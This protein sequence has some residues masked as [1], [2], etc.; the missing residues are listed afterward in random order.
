MIIRNT[1]I[2]QPRAAREVECQGWKGGENSS[3][4]CNLGGRVLTLALTLDLYINEVCFK[5]RL[6]KGH[7]GLWAHKAR[8]EKSIGTQLCQSK[9]A[10]K[11]MHGK[12]LEEFYLNVR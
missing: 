8:I 9:V 5:S 11:Q 1:C 6:F 4:L 3:K 2:A 10:I 7:T 12:C